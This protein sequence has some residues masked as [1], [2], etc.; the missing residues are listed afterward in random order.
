MLARLEYLLE[1]RPFLLN[2]VMLRQN[3]NNI[4]EWLK[5]VSLYQTK[6]TLATEEQTQ[7]E[8]IAIYKR[9]IGELDY[10]SPFVDEP[11]KLFIGLAKFYEDNEQLDEAFTVF[12]E[13]MRVEFPSGEHQVSIIREYC[14]MLIRSN[15]LNKAKDLLQRC[16][17]KVKSGRERVEAKIIV[18]KM[19]SQNRI[20]EVESPDAGQDSKDN[21]EGSFSRDVMF[22]TSLWAL[23]ADLEISLGTIKV[24][25]VS[26]FYF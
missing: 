26:V 18:K 22:S 10:T 2:E 4:G 25:C 21:G 24:G 7:R 13:A 11:T 19:K 14:E 6:R 12:D 23:Y 3:P 16:F 8:I 17:Y 15:N 9:G 1:R 20:E 5:R